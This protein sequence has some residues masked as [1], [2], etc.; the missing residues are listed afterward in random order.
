MKSMYKMLRLLKILLIAI[1]TTTILL[2]IGLSQ[3]FAPKNFTQVYKP[4]PAIVPFLRAIVKMG[5]RYLIKEV[6]PDS[7][8]TQYQLVLDTYIQED[9]LLQRL[10]NVELRAPESRDVLASISIL[11]YRMNDNSQ[12]LEYE[13]KAKSIDPTIVTP[14]ST[15]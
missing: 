9:N 4:K 13:N 1:V 8:A 15:R 12:A 14:F 11:Y 6:F 2:S 3:L 7:L 10:K 5:D